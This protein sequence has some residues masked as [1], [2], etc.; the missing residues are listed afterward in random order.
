MNKKKCI[1]GKNSY[2]TERDAERAASLGMHLSKE[3]KLNLTTY[4]CLY[5]YQWHLTSSKN[6]K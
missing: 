4:M 3:K 1:S 2:E 6:K 5:C